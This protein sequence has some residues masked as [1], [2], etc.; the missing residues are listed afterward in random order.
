MAKQVKKT[1]RAYF[2]DAVMVFGTSYRTWDDQLG[3]YS[4]RFK[5]IP[6]TV[7]MADVAWVGFGGLKWAEWGQAFEKE[8]ADEGEGR[9]LANFE[10]K[11]RPLNKSELKIL[12]RELPRFE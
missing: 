1:L 8:L 2:D 11:F 6:H 7:E 12:L 10:G 3:E 9:T 4:R 5:K